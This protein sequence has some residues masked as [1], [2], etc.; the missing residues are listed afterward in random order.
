MHLV[1]SL[2]GL[3]SQLRDDDARAPSLARLVAVAGRPVREAD[4]I[5]ALLATRYG[6]EHASGTDCPLA[7]VRLAALGVDP[8][9]AFWLAADPVTLVAGRDDV[10]LQGVARDL[11]AHDAAELISLLNAH[12]VGDDIEFTAARP[13]AWFVRVPHAVHLRTRPLAVAM[14]RTLRDFL[15]TGPDAAVWRRWQSEIQMLLH[16][17]PVNAARE[18]HGKAPANSVWFSEGGMRPAQSAR[19]LAVRTFADDGVA[20]ALASHVGRPAHAVPASL[21]PILAESDNADVTI[22][23]PTADFDAVE[24]A[25]LS[26]A[27]SAL[28]NGRLRVVTLLADDA[29]AAFEWTALRPHAWRRMFLRFARP[30]LAPLREAI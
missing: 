6:I 3:L 14:E 19:A 28:M 27:W 8:G 30:D 4:G 21:A 5:D 13:D 29:G 15:P 1:L 22:V 16:E 26:P 10:R 11:D 7:P 23:V 18:R 17:H 20:L 25:W 24:R 12:F 2:P 9:N